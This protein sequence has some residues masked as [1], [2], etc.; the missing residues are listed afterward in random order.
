MKKAYELLNFYTKISGMDWESFV[1]VMIAGMS[2]D[3]EK[4]Q[5]KLIEVLKGRRT[6]I[7]IWDLELDNDVWCISIWDEASHDYI[8]ELSFKV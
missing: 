2:R 1:P 4:V 3:K 8:L 7:S 6:G 5:Q